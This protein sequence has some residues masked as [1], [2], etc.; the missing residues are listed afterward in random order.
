MAL[1]ALT[2]WF[3]SSPTTPSILP[4]MAVL[5]QPRT[6]LVI[7]GRCMFTGRN[8]S[9]CSC[10]S[11]SCTSASGANTTEE[12]CDDC[13]HLMSIHKDYGKSITFIETC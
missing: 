6:I 2:S 9:T 11:G 7:M 4:Q 1:G 5:Q 8:G 13:E 10:T 12:R 3:S